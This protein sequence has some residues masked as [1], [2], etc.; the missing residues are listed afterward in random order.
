MKTVSNTTL[1]VKWTFKMQTLY[2]IYPRMHYLVYD[3]FIQGCALSILIFEALL[4][5]AWCLC[6]HSWLYHTLYKSCFSEFIKRVANIFLFTSKCIY[7][8]QDSVAIIVTL[9]MKNICGTESFKVFA[10]TGHSVEKA[11]NVPDTQMSG[12][13][14]LLGFIIVF[15]SFV[16]YYI[17]SWFFQVKIMVIMV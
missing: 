5:A 1:E 14:C 3:V 13:K 16:I 9:V 10:L 2:L 6:S 15:S 4:L 8:F 7:F 12:K 17:T 11:A